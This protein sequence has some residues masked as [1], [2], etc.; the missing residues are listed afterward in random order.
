MSAWDTGKRVDHRQVRLDRE[1]EDAQRN[2]F[3]TDFHP[4]LAEPIT[5]D[6][7][8]LII[9]ASRGL[10]SSDWRKTQKMEERLAAY[11][12]RLQT[13]ETPAHQKIVRAYFEEMGT[14]FTEF[15]KVV[16]ANLLPETVHEAV[17]Y[18]PLLRGS[19]ER[20]VDQG[21]LDLL[22][23]CLYS[24]SKSNPNPTDPHEVL[25]KMHV[26]AAQSDDVPSGDVDL[27]RMDDE[28][29]D[30]EAA[31]VAAETAAAAARLDQEAAEREHAAASASLQHT[32]DMQAGGSMH[33]E[34]EEEE[35]E[36][37]SDDD[38][39]EGWAPAPEPAAP[40]PYSPDF[41][42]IAGFQHPPASNTALYSD[43]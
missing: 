14:T 26:A 37:Q 11:H 4:D 21:K 27:E 35:E 38:T 17:S 39:P 32:L 20:P 31:A 42:H 5:N 41:Q 30:I 2:Q 13:Y 3:G 40:Y 22:L 12:E 33:P 7:A 8:A 9:E 16:L 25:R 10:V 1:K 23:R 28:M 19:E 36:S 43:V 6:E 29:M 15:E 34:G 18:L 24:Q